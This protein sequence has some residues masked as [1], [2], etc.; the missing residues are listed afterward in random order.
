MK[1]WEIKL[2]RDEA[3]YDMNVTATFTG[4][5]SSLRRG[6]QRWFGGRREWKRWQALL[7]GKSADE[8]L[9]AIR[10]PEGG[11]THPRIR[12]WAMKTLELAGYE[13]H[14]MLLEWEVFWRRK[15]K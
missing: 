6:L 14:A 1:P 11:L 8:Q 12:E 7:Y 9:W 5:F 10:P 13:P 3:L 2:T 15:G 4:W